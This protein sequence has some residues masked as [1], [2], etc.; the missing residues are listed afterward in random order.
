LNSGIILLVSALAQ[1]AP[2]TPQLN[3]I[4]P[5]E[6]CSAAPG[7]EV[8]RKKL[9]SAVEQRDSVAL[10]ALVADDITVTFGQGGEG[11]QEFIATWGLDKP[12]SVKISALWEKL[13][14]ALKLGCAPS[15]DALVSP[16]IIAQLDPMLDG[17]TAFLAVTPGAA[18]RAAPNEQSPVVSLL[19]WDLLTVTDMA[20]DDGWMPAKLV[21]GRAGFVRYDQVRSVLDYRAV[22]ERRDGRWVMTAFVGGD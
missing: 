1:P 2:V 5:V 13:A 19:Q 9:W 6:H 10:L 20:V 8:F 18:M 3:R 16:S 7:F 15:G 17:F 21:D 12:E 22:F 11:K 14:T 4:P